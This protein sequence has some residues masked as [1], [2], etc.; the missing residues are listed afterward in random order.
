V[1]KKLLEKL[2]LGA[3]YVAG[4]LWLMMIYLHSGIRAIVESGLMVVVLGVVGLSIAT[5]GI[6][7]ITGHS[8]ICPNC[9]KMCAKNATS[10]PRRVHR[11]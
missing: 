7:Y 2:L 5:V 11:F 10:C 3:V 4:F 8:L 1:D 9:G 6:V